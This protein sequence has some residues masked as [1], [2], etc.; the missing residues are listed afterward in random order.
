MLK[1]VSSKVSGDSDT[2][3]RPHVRRR[4]STAN[5]LVRNGGGLCR[6]HAVFKNNRDLPADILYGYLFF[7]AGG[8]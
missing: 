2:L 4:A 5:I 3:L 7:A 6:N 1:V 8:P